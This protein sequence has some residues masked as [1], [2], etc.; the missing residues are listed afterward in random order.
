MGSSAVQIA[1]LG[2]LHPENS[3]LNIN[4]GMSAL[5]TVRGRGAGSTGHINSLASYRRVR[6][7]AAL[8]RSDD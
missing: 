8:G 1:M 2:L 4:A 6:F 5:E 3:A 7:F